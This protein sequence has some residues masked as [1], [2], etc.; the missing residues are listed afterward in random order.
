MLLIN[1]TTQTD[2]LTQVLPSGRH[3]SVTALRA[4]R[5]AR[6]FERKVTLLRN[7]LAAMPEAVRSDPV[8]TNEIA[9]LLSKVILFRVA[10]ADET[11]SAAV[12]G[13][14]HREN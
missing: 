14:L 7:M 5:N 9:R 6:Q 10:L 1:S 11:E 12:A 3:V 13:Q 2:T 4:A 8:W